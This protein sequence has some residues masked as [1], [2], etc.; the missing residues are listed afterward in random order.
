M[1]WFQGEGTRGGGL[2]GGQTGFFQIAV[3]RVLQ[4]REQPPRQI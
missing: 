3:F 2:R 4:E 1:P